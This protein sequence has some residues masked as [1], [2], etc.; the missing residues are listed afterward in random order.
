MHLTAVLVDAAG[1]A[2]PSSTT[3][4]LAAVH[5]PKFVA[6]V[7]QSLQNGSFSITFTL[8]ATGSYT[9]CIKPAGHASHGS[10]DVSHG[11]ML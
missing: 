10:A 4:V 11:Y 6:P 8:S 1:I 9:V 2:V 7:T 5:G 3:P